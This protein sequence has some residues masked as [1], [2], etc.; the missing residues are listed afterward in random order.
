[1]QAGFTG[2]R[3]LIGMRGKFFFQNRMAIRE[4]SGK[5]RKG[6]LHEKTPLLVRLWL[7]ILEPLVLPVLDEC[8]SNLVALT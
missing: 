1:M 8:T 4:S 5:P 7:P 2:S 6:P 3:Y